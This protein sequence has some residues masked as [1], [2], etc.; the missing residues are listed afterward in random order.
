MVLQR[1]E[2]FER[3]ET[4][5]AFE[6][7]RGSSSR[8][9]GRIRDWWRGTEWKENHRGNRTVSVTSNVI[10]SLDATWKVHCR[11]TFSLDPART[12]NEVQPEFYDSRGPILPVHLYSTRWICIGSRWGEGGRTLVDWSFRI[13]EIRS[14]SSKSVSLFNLGG[15]WI[16]ASSLRMIIRGWFVRATNV[17]DERCSVYIGKYHFLRVLRII[18]NLYSYFFENTVERWDWFEIVVYVKCL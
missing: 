4:Q 17:K 18:Y 2:L 13:W 7:L 10:N 3:C 14:A 5:G 15:S 1:Y 11:A 6:S 9:L 16:Y 12:M 8:W